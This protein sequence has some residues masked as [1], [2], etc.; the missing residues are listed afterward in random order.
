MGNGISQRARTNRVSETS[1]CVA[2][3]GHRRE[4]GN[5]QW[6]R[7]FGTE[8]SRDSNREDQ[9]SRLRARGPTRGSLLQEMRRVLILI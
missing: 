8:F 4:S 6:E 1:A 7:E 2:I 9:A 3:V 5:D